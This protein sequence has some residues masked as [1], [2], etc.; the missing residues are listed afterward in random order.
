MFEHSRRRFVKTVLGGCVSSL[1]LVSGTGQ[2]LPLDNSFQIQ[3][4]HLYTQDGADLRQ[5]LLT[6]AR[7]VETSAT[8]EVSI[9][10]RTERHEV[11]NLRQIRDQ[12]Y[13]PIVPV[14]QP[15]SAR[16][17][18]NNGTKT[19]ETHRRIQP[20]RK[21]N[22][23]LVHNS[24]Q[25]LGFVDLPSKLRARYHAFIDDAIK[26]C[27]ETRDLPE[28]AQFKWNIETS[29][30]VDDYRQVS[31]EE[32]FRTLMEWVKKGRISIGA[33]YCNAQTDFMSLETL[34]RL[35]SYA[36]SDLTREFGIPVEGAMLD[37][38]PG[39]TWGLVA[40]LAKSGVPYLV[41]G[42]N[43][44][45]NNIQDAPI[46]FYLE[47]PEGSEV[48]IWRSAA[49]PEGM[50]LVP[51]YVDPYLG[52]IVRGLNIQDGEAALGPFFLRYELANYPFD[53]ILLQAAADFVP[54]QRSLCDV[55]QTW[56]SLWAYPRLRIS[57]IPE[58][59]HF[60]ERNFRDRIPRFRGGAPD[61]WVDL[62]IGEANAAALARHTED[63]L[64]DAERLG[65]LGLISGVG[66]SRQGEIATAYKE[67]ALWE[68]HTFE[69]DNFRLHRADI[70]ADESLGGGKG[71]WDEKLA[72]ARTA[73]RIAAEVS[74]QSVDVLCRNISTRADI[75]LTVVN[76][77]SW[78]RNEIVRTPI[79]ASAQPP[80][81]LIDQESGAELPCQTDGNDLVFLAQR[82]PA[83]GYRTYALEPAKAPVAK[84]ATASVQVLENEFYRIE[85][86]PSD[87]TVRSIFDKSLQKEF[88]DDGAAYGF[89]A[90]VYRVDNRTNAQSITTAR[91]YTALGAMPAGDISI[92]PGAAGP[93]YTSV[94]VK[95]TIGYVL[96]F[97]HEIILHA[98]LKRIDFHNRM[99]KRPAYTYESVFHAFPFAVPYENFDTYKL[100][101]PGAVLRPDVDQ[102][103]GSSRDTYAVQHWVSVSRQDYGVIW[104]SADAPL[105]ELGGIQA[106]KHLPHLLTAF[107]NALASGGLYAFLM[108]NHNT[109]DA[110]VAQGGD[111]LFRYA[112]TTHGA[113]WTQNAAHQFGWS[114]MSPLHTHLSTGRRQAEFKAP[115]RGF[116]EISP[117]NVYLPGFK[118]AAD[119]DGVILRLYEGAG[120]A[121]D[122]RVIFNLPGRGVRAAWACDAREL[123]QT[124]LVADES[125]FQ[126]TLAPYETAT[127]RVLLS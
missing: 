91:D 127:V 54:P 29:Y 119:H 63:A 106:E 26:Y 17:V 92:T 112:M 28:D 22:V 19:Q 109:V 95:G 20:A 68:E 70:Y 124:A 38:V 23:F 99:R 50:A 122:A 45:R 75:N 66:P 102:I 11:R 126:I 97:E 32:K 5:I 121:T 90:L 114:F 48:L 83:V 55:V 115:S 56:N 12:Y 81:H 107:E 52:G 100:D 43:G 96:D 98:K 53:A 101:V 13:V 71:H 67:L 14:E 94:K 7:G 9:G 15:E 82:V 41:F 85:L 108:A 31:S 120:L 69:W 125:S 3:E 2:V 72:H 51:Q 40:A 35:L 86:R 123:N 1:P 30:L 24:H 79:P 37:D 93:V 21:W 116:V 118:P 80:F 25:D 104:S 42:A 113:E 110:P 88:V 84:L 6:D 87:G 34:N 76:P 58:F 61:G 60:A 33:L 4:S 10:K 27:E 16:F 73:S 8:I 47:G 18:L 57:A 105:V 78:I 39:F 111:Y 46:L 77:L 44:W 74:G 59:F 103:P 65:T 117:A 49:Y 64:P 36:S 89:N 62:H